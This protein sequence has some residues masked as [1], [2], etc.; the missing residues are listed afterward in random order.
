MTETTWALEAQK[1]GAPPF[2]SSS[3]RK[4]TSKMAE[5][6]AVTKYAIGDI[7]YVPLPA[8]F[9]RK[10]DLSKGKILSVST[11]GLEGLEL[12]IRCNCRGSGRCIG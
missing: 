1:L 8:N 5:A 2:F 9:E 11:I 6:A 3:R 4:P 7:V 12:Y 10:S